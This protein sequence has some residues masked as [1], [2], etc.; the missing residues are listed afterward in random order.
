MQ[1]RIDRLEN[2]VLSLMNNGS[3]AGGALN[4]A[5]LN[6]P[7]QYPGSMGNNDPSRGD[8]S[9]ADS[10]TMSAIDDGE[11]YESDTEQVT[12]SLGVMK[13]ASEN[14]AYYF[15]DAHWLSV[16][17]DVCLSARNSLGIVQ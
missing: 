12:K 3:T 5:P 13:V 4:G 8:T 2:L 1:N 7:L 6:P 9:Q 16:L 17:G 11:S 14:N 15:S 10:G